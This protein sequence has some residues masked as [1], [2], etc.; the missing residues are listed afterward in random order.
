MRIVSANLDAFWQHPIVW[1]TIGGVWCLSFFGLVLMGVLHCP[2]EALSIGVL[3]ISFV[4]GLVVGYVQVQIMSCPFAWC[5]PNYALAARRSL[6]LAGLCVSPISAILYVVLLG[7]DIHAFGQIA[8]AVCAAFGASLAVFFFGAALA[9]SRTGV[10]IGCL[11]ISLSCVLHMT[12]GMLF[13]RLMVVVAHAVVDFPVLVTVFGL[14][15]VTAMWRRI[16]HVSRLRTLRINTGLHQYRPERSSVLGSVNGAV[17]SRIERLGLRAMRR[18]DPMGR[19][20]CACGAVYAAALW[21]TAHGWLVGIVVFSWLAALGLSLYIPW[22]A[23]LW[24]GYMSMAIPAL[25]RRIEPCSYAGPYIA[26]GRRERFFATLGLSVVL[27]VLLILLAMSMVFAS[28]PLANLLTGRSIS[29]AGQNAVPLSPRLA[30]FPLVLFP[31]CGFLGLTSFR[32]PGLSA[33]SALVLYAWWYVTIPTSYIL[34]GAA[35]AWPLF[36]LIVRWIAF[37]TDLVEYR[38][39]G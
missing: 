5:L 36:V 29:L 20:Q 2:L 4:A 30:L 18:F 31:L 7:S 17:Q 37:H 19:W 24:V 15:V 26:G 38:G 16:G 6:F 33:F 23:I 32:G 21:M 22:T 25:I 3:I 34:T 13:P 8:V 14:V 28:V 11:L 1:L 35:L 12:S 27:C 39:R 10:M 9:S